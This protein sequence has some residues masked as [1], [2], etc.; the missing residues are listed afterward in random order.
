MK[1]DLCISE[2]RKLSNLKLKYIYRAVST[3][4]K[5]A[6][7][8]QMIK[9]KT[10][11]QCTLVVCTETRQEL[12][13]DNYIR[14]IC[15]WLRGEQSKALPS[16]T[17]PFVHLPSVSIHSSPYS[18]HNRDSIYPSSQS[19]IELVLFYNNT[20]LPYLGDY[21]PCFY[22]LFCKWWQRWY[23]LGAAKGC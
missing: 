22:L 10:A 3:C 9:G 21:E 4:I 12:M 8:V 11:T 2:Y 6:S 15:L 17:S 16:C 5:I 20:I 1:N 14:L 23:Y 7:I 13:I 18:K 19:H